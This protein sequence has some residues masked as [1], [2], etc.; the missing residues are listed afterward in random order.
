MAE[1]RLRR[2]ISRQMPML[3]V[4]VYMSIIII[5]NNKHTY[6]SM[7]AIFYYKMKVMPSIICALN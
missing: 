6:I 3:Y 7:Y 4:N 1:A 2:N 5:H